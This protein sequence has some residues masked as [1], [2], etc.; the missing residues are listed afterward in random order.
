MPSEYVLKLDGKL[1]E[2]Q[3]PPASAPLREHRAAA[4]AL[5]RLFPGVQ[6]RIFSV[7][8]ADGQRVTREIRTELE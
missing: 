5:K 8:M 1:G 6:V 2:P 3:L 4:R 7:R